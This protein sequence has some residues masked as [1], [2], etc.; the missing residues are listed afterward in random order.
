MDLISLNLQ[1]ARD[2][3]IPGYNFF[4]E[5][6]NLTR[7][8]NFED[9]NNEIAPHL[10]DR[11]KKIYE[12]VDDIDLFTGGLIE[13]PL[14]GGSVGPTFG[15]VIG[16]QFQRLRKGDRFWHETSDPFVRFSESQLTEIRKISLAKVVC[17][18]SD[19]INLIQR[20]A[21]DLPDPFL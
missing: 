20:I 3:G 15:C 16:M 21:M 5:K 13:N 1:R 4:R 12:S 19:S 6:C 14:H 18:N 17:S 2:H 10:V 8:V 7:A 9:L 11:L